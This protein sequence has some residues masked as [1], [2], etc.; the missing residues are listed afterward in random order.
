[1][2]SRLGQLLVRA[3]K[4][5]RAFLGA[6][7]VECHW[8]TTIWSMV[9]LTEKIIRGAWDFSLDWHWPGVWRDSYFR[10][11]RPRVD[12]RDSGWAHRRT[13]N[14]DADSA[15]EH[16]CD[17]SGVGPWLARS[18]WPFMAPLF[19]YAISLDLGDAAPGRHPMARPRSIRWRPCARGTV[20]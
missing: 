9:K 11:N 19:L 16:S 12:G 15:G 8:G 4:R 18:S 17:E 1:M 2:T 13:L 5:T 20:R 6:D 10:R 7:D 14:V 3:G